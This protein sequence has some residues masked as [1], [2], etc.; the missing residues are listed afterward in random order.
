MLP[1]NNEYA[2]MPTM[3][4]KARSTGNGRPDDFDIPGT[5]APQQ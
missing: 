4:A 2:V 1:Q 3:A 5:L